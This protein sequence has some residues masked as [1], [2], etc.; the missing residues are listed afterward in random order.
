HNAIVSPT[1][2]AYLDADVATVDLR[3]VYSFE[4]I[5]PDLS[6]EEAT[7]IMGGEC[8]MWT[9]RA[10]QELVDSKVFPRILAMSERLWSP[11]TTRDFSQFRRRVQTHYSRLDLLGVTY[12]AEAKPVKV[13]ANFDPV[14]SG[15]I[16]QLEAGELGL[17]IFYT[18]GDS[19]KAIPYQKP[20]MFT[21]SV[22]LEAQAFRHKKPYGEPTLFNFQ[23]HKALGKSLSLDSTYHIKY[24]AGGPLG[25]VN[26][27]RGSKNFREGGWQG[28]EEI[29]FNGIVDLG[30]VNRVTSVMAGF[31]Q[32]I[33]SWIF[34]PRNMRI[35]LSL[36]GIHFKTVAEKSHSVSL[37]EQSAIIKELQVDVYSIPARYVKIE[38]ENVGRC[39][40]WHPGA[41]GKAWIFVDEIVV[42]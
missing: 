28:Y 21:K 15:C 29:D 23:A 22:E 2:H 24:T 36:D 5:P 8:N 27:I 11:E 26:G 40:E 19:N 10:P 12:G 41:G 17:D 35:S 25:L 32:D 13:H 4:P 20:L 6:K 42:K 9:E 39:P 34:L 3:K 16:V 30:K 18:L 31:L 1:S 37:K 38:V 14:K 7:L 33:G